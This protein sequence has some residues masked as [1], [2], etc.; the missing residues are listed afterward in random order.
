[1]GD[2]FLGDALGSRRE[3]PEKGYDAPES[4]GEGPEKLR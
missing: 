4:G 1:M 2:S 3:V